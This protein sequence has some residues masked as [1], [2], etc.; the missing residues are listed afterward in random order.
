V[1]ANLKDLSSKQLKQPGLLTL[2]GQDLEAKEA[3]SKELAVLHSHSL[4][5]ADLMSEINE[6]LEAGASVQQ[7]V[8]TNKRVMRHMK[9]INN[10]IT[11]KVSTQMSNSIL[12]RR[13][14]YIRSVPE[15]VPYELIA[16]F[17]ASPFLEE[18]LF[19]IDDDDIDWL[20]DHR[21]NLQTLQ[22]LTKTSQVAARVIGSDFKQPL[23]VQRTP[24]KET[25]VTQPEQFKEEAEFKDQP[26]HQGKEH[27]FTG[28][29]I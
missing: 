20:K 3:E 12:Q 17:R 6:N 22:I 11:D 7:V 25:R 19:D 23:P 13:D 1:N 14:S 29:K 10:L 2:S 21:K 27:S 4:W 8:Q 9:S 5:I 15:P 24:V 26:S 28:N 18:R 16:K